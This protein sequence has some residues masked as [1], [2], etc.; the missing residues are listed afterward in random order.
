MTLV[1]FNFDSKDVRVIEIEG[2]PWFLAIDV[3]K[4]LDH[5]DSAKAVSRLDADEKLIRTLFVSGQ[6]RETW[7]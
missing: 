5:S 7:L 3:C 4:I 2:S 1:N 6:N